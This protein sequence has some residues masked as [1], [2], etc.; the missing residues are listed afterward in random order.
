MF[1]RVKKIFELEAITGILLIIAAVAALFVA[2]SS[3][4]EAYHHHL[5]YDFY[6][7]SVHAWINDALMAVFFLLVGLEL[8]EEI[9]A[10]ELSTKSKAML[11]A[12]AAIGGV[13]AP[14]LIFY[15]YNHN[16]PQNLKGFAIPTATDIAFAYGV[17]CLFGNKISRSLKV[18]LISLAIFDDMAAILIIA[19]FYSQNIN[20]IY[21][22]FSILTLAVLGVLS[23][24]K[25]TSIAPYLTVGLVLWF[26]V[27]KTGIHPT[28]AG[29]TL[30]MFIPRQKDVLHK[31]I[32]KIAP[33][34]N[35]VILP[36]FA[37]ANS[38]VKISGFSAETFSSPLVLGIIMG[39][40]FGKQLGVMLFS[41]VAVKLKLSELPRGAKGQSTWFEFYGVV[42]LT[43]I[44]FT[45]SF[46]IGSLAFIKDPVLFEEVKIAVLSASLLSAIFGIVA[47]YIA[48]KKR[49]FAKKSIAEKIINSLH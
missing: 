3:S 18:F 15:A 13:I 49:E 8:K 26:M 12:I 28:I 14:A 36:I 37:F 19:I 2:N 20:L 41:F 16:H 44:G 17:I 38:G 23:F 43:G 47:I 33:M 7:L 42:V 34:V 6:G 32:K 24:K 45:M 35:F 39:L 46:F 29:V 31:L 1:R 21:I 48:L 25:C 40:F 4:F 10:G 5:S 9:A 11:P 22:G 27:L 30:A